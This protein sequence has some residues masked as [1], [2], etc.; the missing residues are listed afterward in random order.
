MPLLKKWST[1]NKTIVSRETDN[2]G[3]YELGNIHGV[4]NIGEGKEPS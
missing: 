4:I 1:F 2:F 3:V